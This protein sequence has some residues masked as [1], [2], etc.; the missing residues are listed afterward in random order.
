MA[1]QNARSHRLIWWTLFVSLVL[2]FIYSGVLTRNARLPILALQD[3][4]WTDTLRV[5]EGGLPD[6]QRRTLSTILPGPVIGQLTDVQIAP[7]STIY[8]LDAYGSLWH[9]SSRLTILAVY[10]VNPAVALGPRAPLSIVFDGSDVGIWDA[11]T[12]AIH[13]IGPSA[14]PAR[15]V[16]PIDSRDVVEGFVR[17]MEPPR[18]HG[19]LMRLNGLTAVEVRQSVGPGSTEYSL[20]TLVILSETHIDSVLLGSTSRYAVR[21]GNMWIDSRRGP[22]FGVQVWWGIRSD[23]RIVIANAGWPAI[24]MISMLSERPV[25]WI[26][27]RAERQELSKRQVVGHWRSSY[28]HVFP[29]SSRRYRDARIDRLQRRYAHFSAF[30]ADS[31]PLFSQLIVDAKDNVWVRRFDPDAWPEGLSD[32]WDVF[33]ATGRYCA[34]VRI[35][36]MQYIFDIGSIGVVGSRRHRKFAHELFLAPADVC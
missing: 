13:W 10:R 7:D 5:T 27:W 12:T 30:V 28:E 19:R 22:L 9:L 35:P 2:I 20:A 34:I 3:V 8:A 24:R 18:Q 14:K 11:A 36:M 1:R 26:A 32:V 15:E 21:F 31:A 33:D 16:L 25:R 17:T 6:P 29:D 23:G 4:Q